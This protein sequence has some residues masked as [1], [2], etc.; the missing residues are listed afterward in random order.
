M[1]K[2]IFKYTL[3]VDGDLQ[4]I[5]MDNEGEITDGG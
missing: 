5:L 1:N 3:K 4:K 2:K